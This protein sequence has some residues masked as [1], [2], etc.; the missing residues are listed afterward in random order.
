MVQFAR[1]LI[2]IPALNRRQ[3][4]R[5]SDYHSFRFGRKTPNVWR[6]LCYRGPANNVI[7]FQL[8]SG[9]PEAADYLNSSD[10]VSAELQI[11]VT[12]ADLFDPEHTLPNARENLFRLRSGRLVYFTYIERPFRRW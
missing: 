8:P 5:A 12:D 9:A 6:K 2:E 10:G 1:V 4:D 3:W 7:C 11:V